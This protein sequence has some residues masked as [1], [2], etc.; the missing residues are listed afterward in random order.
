MP[1]VLSPTDTAVGSGAFNR[2]VTIEQPTDVDDGQGGSTRTWVV[3]LQTMA[4]FQPFKGQ[5][6]W[7]TGQVYPTLWTKVL[8]RY[9]PDVNVTPTMRLRYGNRIYNIR[10]VEVPAEALTT[11]EMLCEQLQI[12][13]SGHS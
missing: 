5:E 2:P 10:S 7:K 3:V 6:L 12:S 1:D 4:H 11:I 13:G 8:I 9:R